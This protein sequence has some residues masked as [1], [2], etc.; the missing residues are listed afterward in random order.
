MR[1]GWWRLSVRGSW[2]RRLM[3]SRWCLRAY[4]LPYSFFSAFWF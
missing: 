4:W 1:G 2:E 3:D